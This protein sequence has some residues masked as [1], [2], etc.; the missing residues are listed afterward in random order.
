M[1]TSEQMR[2]GVYAGF[3]WLPARSAARVN[4][5]TVIYLRVQ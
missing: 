4:I 3:V 2:K 1:K 5:L